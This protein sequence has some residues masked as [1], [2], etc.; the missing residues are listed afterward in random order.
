[1]NKIKVLIV[2]LAACLYMG[3][4]SATTVNMGDLTAYGE[5]GYA[6]NI[7]LAKGPFADTYDFYI[8]S[9]SDVGG[10]VVNAFVK[11]GKKTWDISNLSLTLKSGST[12]LG[13]GAAFDVLSLAQ[14]SYSFVVTGEAVGTQGGKYFFNVLAIPV[15][16]PDS[17]MMILFGLSLIG[18][19]VSRRR[20]R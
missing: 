19:G 3:M 6:A 11:V 2:G 10:G 9:I 18:W 17:W 4:A 15:P 1:M 16:E 5:A 13:Q 12:V 20:I 14:G 8:P 7:T